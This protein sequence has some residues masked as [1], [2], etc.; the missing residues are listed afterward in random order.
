MC[1]KI[2]STYF[3]S[4]SS[5]VQSIS[6]TLLLTMA[7]KENLKVVCRDVGN[8]FPNA[9]TNEKAHA[10][11]GEEFGERQGCIVELIKSLHGMSTAS[12]SFALCACDFVR[13]LGFIPTRADLDTWIKKDPNYD[14]CSCTST[15][16]DDFFVVDTEP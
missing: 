7:E 8:A 6:M 10:V 13:T 14:G 16:V 3:E 11:A 15:H 9:P 12:R 2:D 4:H 5:L 1:H